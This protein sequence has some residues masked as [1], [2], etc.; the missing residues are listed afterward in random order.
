M[1]RSSGRQRVWAHLAWL[2]F[3][4]LL[5]VVMHVPI[6]RPMAE[7]IRFSDKLAHFSAYFVLT[8]LGG[9]ALW[10]RDKTVSST[11]PDARRAVGV[12]LVVW[13]GVYAGWA[14][15]DE[16]LQGYVNRSPSVGD[17]AADVAGVAVGTAVVW[18]VRVRRGA[19]PPWT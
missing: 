7:R 13:A 4:A 9:W 19:A 15:L 2:G 3:W 11:A 18:Y 14:V 16:W 5:F 8:L 17:W 12:P 1:F 10:S 6:P